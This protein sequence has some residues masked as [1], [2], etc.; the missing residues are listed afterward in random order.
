MRLLVTYVSNQI[1]EVIIISVILSTHQ[2]PRVLAQPH[3]LWLVHQNLTEHSRFIKKV[4]KYFKAWY[5]YI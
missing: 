4:Y 1:C 3:I 2:R 5:W